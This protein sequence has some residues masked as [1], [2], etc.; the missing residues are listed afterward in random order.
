MEGWQNWLNQ[1]AQRG[2][3]AQLLLHDVEFVSLQC[4]LVRA[5]AIL[6]GSLWPDLWIPQPLL[7]DWKCIFLP[8][9]ND[10]CLQHVWFLLRD[11]MHK[12]G[13]CRHAVS[14]CLCVCVCVTFV[15]CA[16]TNKDIFKVF[17]PSGSQA[18]LVFP[19]RTGWRYSDGNPPNGGVECKAGIK[20]DDFRPISRSISETV[21]VKW[22]HAARQFVSIEFSCHPYNIAWLPQRRP[23][24]KQKCRKNSDFWTYALTWAS[25]NL[26]SLEDI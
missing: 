22:A 6:D 16:K 5:S 14:V 3:F 13:I 21:I 24:G 7:H 9:L 26:E 20:N 8:A 17:S 15:S 11:A 25:Y 23:Q 4:I 2:K 10:I 19:H 1:Q 18:I 12:R